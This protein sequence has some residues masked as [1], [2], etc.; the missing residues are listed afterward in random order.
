MAMDA[1]KAC[2]RVHDCVIDT[3][4]GGPAPSGRVTHAGVVELVD[5]LDLGSS[6]A[7]HGGSNPFARTSFSY[8]VPVGSGAAA[9]FLDSDS[10]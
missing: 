2:N 1:E 4:S 6:G 5:T 8:R 10:N 3:A 9:G 7:S